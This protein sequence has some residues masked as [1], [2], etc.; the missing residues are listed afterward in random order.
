MRKEENPPTFMLTFRKYLATQDETISDQDAIN[1]YNDYKME[2]KKQA[3]E[4]YFQTHKDE[5]W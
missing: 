3:C 1:K 5:E 4:K 2:Y